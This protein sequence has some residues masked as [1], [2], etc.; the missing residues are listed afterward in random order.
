MDPKSEK[1]VKIKITSQEATHIEGVIDIQPKLFSVSS[2]D[3]VANFCEYT[4]FISDDEGKI[5]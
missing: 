3:I 5:L 1:E 4:R 2:V